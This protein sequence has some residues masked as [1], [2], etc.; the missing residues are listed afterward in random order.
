M[1]FLKN[2]S[3]VLILT[4]V[5]ILFS[6]C[7]NG[8]SD[9]S[10]GSFSVDTTIATI[11]PITE[12]PLPDVSK[13][14]SAEREYIYDYSGVLSAEQKSGLNS[15]CELLYKERLINIAVYITDTIDGKTPYQF[16][17]EVYSDLYQGRGSGLL[18]LINNDTKN[19]YLYRTGSC[20]TAIPDG[21][22]GIAFFWATQ[23]IVVGDY[24]SAILRVLQL[25]ERCP[26]HVFDNI[27]LFSNDELTSLETKLLDNDKSIFVL[28][29]SNGTGKT[30]EEICRNYYDRCSNKN[31]GYMIMIDTKSNS[32]T[33][34][35]D[36]DLPSEID[37]AKTSAEKMLRSG[38][39]SAAVNE[40]I[41]ALE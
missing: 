31:D 21:Y 32:L 28:A 13:L 17:D 30:N 40:I 12:I 34:V 35:S 9:V 23:D 18:L 2:F 37:K 15:Y 1:I 36:N 33:I 11:E 3:A 14:D 16:A 7:S 5:L 38:E 41:V 39:V 4:A 19:D 29:T 6:S 22:E 25:G 10:D 20:L 27:G 26:L 24:Y 8:V